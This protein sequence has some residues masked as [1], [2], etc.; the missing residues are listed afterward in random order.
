MD[1]PVANAM[2]N[3]SDAKDTP[4]DWR[5]CGPHSAFHAYEPALLIFVAVSK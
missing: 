5:Y 4:I 3:S 1:A 2:Q